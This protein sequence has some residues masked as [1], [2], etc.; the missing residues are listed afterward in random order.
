MSA[1]RR[2]PTASRPNVVLILA[3]DMGF[4]DIGCFGS[5]IPTPN[6]DALSRRGVRFTQMYNCARC[7]PTRASLLTGMY[8]HQ[9]GVGH[10]VSDRGV[11]P[12]YQGFLRADRPTLG[13][14][15]RAGGYRTCY[16]G[17]WHVSPGLP[18]LGGPAEPP[19]GPRNPT[20]RSRGFDEFYGTL[21][22]CANYFNPHGLME[23]DVRIEAGGDFYY[24][25]AI[26]DAACRM[27]GGVRQDPRPFLLH[28]CYTAP[29]WPLHARPGDIE[30]HAG[31]YGRGWDHFRTARHETLRGL[32]LVDP[33]WEITPRD[34][35]S[36]D[37]HAD[38]SRRRAW[39]ALRMAVY[40]A[41]VESMDRGIGRVLGALRAAGVEEDT[42]V[43]F[44][45]DN[46]GCAEFLNE[47]GDGRTW[48][49]VYRHTARAGETCTV[50]N[51]EGLAPG[52]A[53]TFMSY[54]LPWANVSNAPFRLYKHWVH[55]GGIATPCIVSWPRA[56]AA[57]SVVRRPCHVI[58]VM[59]TC[60]EAAGAACPPEAEGESM[61]PLLPGR[62]APRARPLFWEHEGNA[63]VRDG[64][65]K[66]VRRHPGAWEL[67]DMGRDRT[68]MHDL[69]QREPARAA[70]LARAYDEWAARCGV[71]PWK[72]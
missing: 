12:A 24:T 57:G 29:H 52:P 51:I 2:Q 15:L 61:L 65:W 10:M 9:A 5:E 27:I 36:R 62:D 60:L 44:L 32:G 49:G 40:A 14:A 72:G 8:P 3:D 23:Q 66:L 58:D 54:G 38:P 34:P 6:L 4:S 71:L 55:E 39:E 50:G 30:K 18:V 7:C 17:K 70:G 22:G 16:A 21:A 46:G 37:F 48:P 47:D 1:D 59:A 28:V 33:R 69:A 13:E 25:D 45:S 67:Y 56:A 42:L 64:D 26:S 11:G 20:P 41:Q 53:T 35:D 31:V 43:L 68:E 19:G 63:A